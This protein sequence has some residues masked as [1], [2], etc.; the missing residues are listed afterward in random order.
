MTDSVIGALRVVAGFDAAYFQEALD[1]TVRDARMGAKRM[2]EEVDKGFRGMASGIRGHLEDTASQIPLLGGQVGALGGVFGAVAVGGLAAFAVGLARAREAMDWA[3]VLTDQAAYIGVSTEA[4]QEYRY[5]AD[6]AGVSV[7]DMEASLQTLNGTLGAMKTGIGDAKLKKVFDALGI[8]KADLQPIKD[9]SQLLPILA[10]KISKLG[11]QAEQ[12][13]IANKLGIG[14]LLPLLQQGADGMEAMRAK[15]RELGLVISNE[16][17]TSL[18]AAQRK[19]EVASQ[20]IDTQL[21]VAFAGLAPVITGVTQTLADG[22]RMMTDYIARFQQVKGLSSSAL[23]AERDRLTSRLN[24]PN[25]ETNYNAEAFAARIN[26]I[27]NGGLLTG[28]LPNA[29]GEAIRRRDE[30]RLTEV[31]LEISRDK[32]GAGQPISITPPIVASQID[33]SSGRSSS[34]SDAQKEAQRKAGLTAIRKEMDALNKSYDTGK[35]SGDAYAVAMDKLD[36]KYANLAGDIRQNLGLSNDLL[37]DGTMP[38]FVLQA[39]K[40]KDIVRDVT[41]AIPEMGDALEKSQTDFENWAVKVGADVA[42]ALGD[43]AGY[44][45]DAGEAIERMIRRMV[46]SWTTSGA[47]KLFGIGADGKATGDGLIGLLKG[48]GSGSFM[49]GEN[50]QTSGW[51][52][53][54]IGS[55][56]KKSTSGWSLAGTL[57]SIFGGLPGL[58][59]G[60]MH[61]N[62]GL[63]WVG[64]NGPELVGMPRGGQVFP[65]N[66]SAALMNPANHM[67]GGLMVSVDKSKYFDVAVSEVAAPMARQAAVTGAQGGA[68]LAQIQT[69]RSRKRRL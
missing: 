68:Q 56:L 33:V 41:D 66:V 60:T 1:K 58:A 21:R 34:L 51:G 52:G 19:A 31:L 43:I 35:I 45:D 9:A 6:E 5:M 36:E 38:G 39:D 46:A 17:V 12:A 26:Y 15:A 20:V 23:T 27:K 2:Q 44:G 57:G 10:E 61:A 64:E 67:S 29:S 48:I 24:D 37:L 59:S 28:K 53:I 16:T 30:K 54:D 13:Q 62:G 69:A 22:I 11:T 4:L 40:V 14:S 65:A 55:I 7:E 8:T 49:P 42:Y 47:L 32:A 18:D 50:S 25:A 63:T 3:A